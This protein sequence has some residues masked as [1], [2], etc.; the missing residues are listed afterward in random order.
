MQSHYFQPDF[1]HV[2]QLREL[3][4]SELPSSCRLDMDCEELE[5]PQ[6]ANWPDL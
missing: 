3:I 1:A 4:C 2:D 5:Y 6:S